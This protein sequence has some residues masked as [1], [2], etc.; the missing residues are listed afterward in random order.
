MFIVALKDLAE[1]KERGCFPSS[2]YKDLL[3]IKTYRSML[4]YITYIIKRPDSAE[5]AVDKNPGKTEVNEFSNT[6]GAGTKWLNSFHCMINKQSHWLDMLEH[7]GFLASSIWLLVF[8]MMNLTIKGKTKQNKEKK[9]N[10]FSY[11]I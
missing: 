2:W 3:C 9:N 8:D 5:K 11:C 6:V 1:R 10:R 4:M 7:M